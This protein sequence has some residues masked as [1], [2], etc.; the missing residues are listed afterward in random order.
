MGRW[1]FQLDIEFVILEWTY[2]CECCPGGWVLLK[3]GC[4]DARCYLVQKGASMSW[5]EERG[6]GHL[7]P[8][9]VGTV[10]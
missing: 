4:I 3:G 1:L 5:E 8:S 7:T 2:E 9:G 10:L 6:G